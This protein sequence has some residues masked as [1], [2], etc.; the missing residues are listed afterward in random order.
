MILLTK[1]TPVPSFIQSYFDSIEGE[2]VCSKC[3]KQILEYSWEA[4]GNTYSQSIAHAAHVHVCDK[5][6]FPYDFNS[7]LTLIEQ[8]EA[9]ALLPREE[10]A[11]PR[12]TKRTMFEE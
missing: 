7:P 11:P 4:G 2:L 6:S 8:R 3:K 10:T 5:I 12:K 9:Y 1:R